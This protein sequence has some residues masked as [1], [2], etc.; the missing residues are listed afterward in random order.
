MTPP[1]ASPWGVS[2]G[3]PPEDPRGIPAG[4]PPQGPPGGPSEGPPWGQG[5]LVYMG[6]LGRPRRPGVYD[7]GA[8]VGVSEV[9]AVERHFTDS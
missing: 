6:L 5:D 7:G 9:A 1:G 4:D 2:L 8:L 3:I